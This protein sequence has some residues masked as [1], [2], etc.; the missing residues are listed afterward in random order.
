MNNLLLLLKRILIKLTGANFNISFSQTGED[1]IIKFIFNALKIKEITYLDIGA[2]H[3][4]NMSNTYLFYLL[5]FK[6]TCIEPDPN[7][8]KKIKQRRKRD[9]CLNIGVG[10][11]NITKSLFYIM[12]NPVFNTFSEAEAKKMELNG[13]SRIVKTINME[14]LTINDLIKNK[15]KKCPDLIS[16]DVEG[17]DY[18][19]MQEFDFSQHRPKIFCIETVS[20]S[21][22][23]NGKKSIDIIDLLIQN[24]YRIVADTYINTIF[25]DNN[26]FEY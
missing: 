2:N 21:A 7:L 8:F 6:G 23:L 9:L 24:N 19:I 26:L 3:P 18:E 14:L 11:K 10:T 12:E 4:F 1:I 22:V 5:G 15:L 17:I 25:V 16:L 20:Y 13:D